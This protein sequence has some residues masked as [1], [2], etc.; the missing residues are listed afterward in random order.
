MISQTASAASRR[1][2][3]MRVEPLPKRQRSDR[4]N[5]VRA[6]DSHHLVLPM[7]GV[8][9]SGTRHLE[10]CAVEAYDPIVRDFAGAGPIQT[11]VRNERHG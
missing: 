4:V 10:S 9:G 8:N 1:S 7:A 2:P 3:V 5:H 11:E 6:S